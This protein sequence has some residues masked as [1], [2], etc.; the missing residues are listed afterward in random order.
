MGAAYKIA[1][2]LIVIGA[3][4]IGSGILMGVRESANYMVET[5]FGAL[6]L[7][8][9]AFMLFFVREA[10]REFQETA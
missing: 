3:I 5:G 1:A 7:A 2:V 6:G 8:A 4:A 9:A 10:V